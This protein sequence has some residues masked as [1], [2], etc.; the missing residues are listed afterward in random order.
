MLLSLS[1]F[2]SLELSTTSS[3]YSPL[4]LSFNGGASSFCEKLKSTMLDLEVGTTVGDSRYCIYP[5]VIPALLLSLKPISVVRGVREFR[6]T[7]VGWGRRRLKRMRNRLFSDR[8]LMPSLECTM[9]PNSA[10]GRIAP[11]YCGSYQRYISR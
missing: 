11:N 7:R 9:K 3:C 6:S 1:L 2:F 4:P 8:R 5:Y 10:N